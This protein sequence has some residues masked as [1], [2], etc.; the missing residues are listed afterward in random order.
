MNERIKTTIADLRQNS[1]EVTAAFSALNVAQLNWKPAEKSWSVGQCLDHLIVTHSLYLPEF[2]KIAAGEVKPTFW[3]KVSPMSGY[4]GRFLIKSLDPANAKPMRTTS[5]AFPSSSAL[6]ADIV[7]RFAVHQQE[8]VAALGKFPDDL[9]TAMIITSP[10]MGLV[11]Y[12]LDD[13]LKFVPMHCQR[14]FN[15][16]KRVTETPG[17]PT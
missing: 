16:A 8:I 11:T 1:A 4:F 13:T 6:G 14:H 2:E 9:D 5:K 15:Q 10:L 12:S 3:Q 7:D 17:F